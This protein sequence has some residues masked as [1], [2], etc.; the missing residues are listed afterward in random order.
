MHNLETLLVH[1]GLMNTGGVNELLIK[2][3]GVGINDLQHKLP[4]GLFSDVEVVSASTVATYE[5]H[6]CQNGLK[7]VTTTA[8]FEKKGDL[9]AITFKGRP[10]RSHASYLTISQAINSRRSRR[11]LRTSKAYIKKPTNGSLTNSLDTR[12]Y[13][14]IRTTLLSGRPSHPYF[15]INKLAPSVGPALKVTLRRTSV[16]VNTTPLVTTVTKP[17]NNPGEINTAPRVNIQELCEEYYENILPIIM[18]KVRHERR[19][20]V[21][22]KLDFGE[23]P[24]ERIGEDSHYSDTRAKNA[25]PER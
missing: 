17:A 6:G 20:D 22:T 16:M 12:D 8:A 14:K 7:P 2:L 11:T 13:V 3:Q 5:E 24:Q 9:D 19:K 15:C 18:G 4:Q 23:D 1:E 10:T 21:H 25:E